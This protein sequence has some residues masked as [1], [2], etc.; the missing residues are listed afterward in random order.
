MANEINRTIQKQVKLPF[1]TAFEISWNGMRTRFWRSMI[2]AAGVALGIAFLTLVFTNSLMKWQKPIRIDEGYVRIDG[3]ITSNGFYDAYKSVAIDKAKDFGLPENV[4]NACLDKNGMINLTDVYVGRYMYYHSIEMKETRTKESKALGKVNKTFYDISEVDKSINKR[5]AV[6]ARVPNGVIDILLPKGTKSFKASQLAYEVTAAPLKIA[7]WERQIKKYSIYKDIDEDKLNIFCDANAN[8]VEDI[9]A[10]AGGLDKETAD[11]NN[12]MIVNRNERRFSVDLEGKKNI[13]GKV[14][15]D[16]SAKIQSG[17]FITIADITE[18]YRNIWL[19]VMS[20]L[21]CTVGIT[22]S[23]LM[24]VTE[25]FKEIGTMKCLGALDSFIVTLFVIE[26]AIMGMSASFIGFIF[27]FLVSIF[28]NAAE[29]GWQYVF[30]IGF[31]DPFKI[32]LLAIFAGLILTFLAAIPPARKAANMP[33]AI[34]L[35]SE[36]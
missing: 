4:I 30:A 20:L 32:F 24:S 25:R 23:M 2:T 28:I 7:Y 13:D 3:Q 16:G 11:K 27:G 5:S 33:A 19:A 31:I 15:Q 22:N 18:T 35:R 36:I 29:K 12:V 34:A 21:V 1:K 14:K 26:S 17:D 10:I 9:I 8:T 6:K